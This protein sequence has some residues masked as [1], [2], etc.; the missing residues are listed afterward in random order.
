MDKDNKNIFLVRPSE[1]AKTSAIVNSI[2]LQHTMSGW[3]RMMCWYA[4]N[5]KK[6]LDAKGN[7]S[8]GKIEPNLRK[9]DGFQAYVHAICCIGYLPEDNAFPET[10]FAVMSY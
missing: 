10:G 9:T 5:T 2:F 8:Y 7:I 4:N 1:I 3:D 6:M